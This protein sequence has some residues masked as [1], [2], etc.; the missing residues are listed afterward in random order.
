MDETGHTTLCKSCYSKKNKSWRLAN[1]EKRRQTTKKWRDKNKEKTS[2]YSRQRIEYIK[3]NKPKQYLLRKARTSAKRRNILCD[4]LLSDI[5]DIPEICPVLGIPLFY[6]KNKRTDNTP[7]IDR[8]DNNLGYTKDN[9]II[10]SWRANNLK[11][12]GT[13]DEFRKLT[14]FLNKCQYNKK[15]IKEQKISLINDTISIDNIY[16]LCDWL[17][18]FPRLTKGELTKEFEQKFAEYIG[19][20]FS[21]FVNSG[22]S[23]ILLALLTLKQSNLLNNNKIIIPSLSWATDVSIPDI[24]GFECILCDINLNDLSLELENLENLFIKHNPS[25]LL[26]VSVLGLPP[27]MNEIKYLCDKY[28]V[29]LIE[30]ACESLGSS[31]N[32]KKIGSFGEISVFSSYYGHHFS[33][34]EGGFICTNN[35]KLYELGLM[36]RSHGW[37]R[38]LSINR[39]DELRKK[40]NINEFENLYTFYQPGLNIRNTE[41]GSFLGIQQMDKLCDIVLKREKNFFKMKELIKNNQISFQFSPTDI[42][43]NFAFPCL[44]EER[45]KYITALKNENIEARPLIAGSISLHPW[46]KEKYGYVKMPNAE[47]LHYDGFYLPNH[48]DLT[49]DDIRLI[50]KVINETI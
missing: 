11:H 49:D 39:Q 14:Q 31:F 32:N 16:S 47:R 40:Y 37:S 3:Q 20:K 44:F 28:N 30:D 46:W 45:D 8:I 15:N 34:I 22:S 21:I 19:T 13:Y 2:I 7:S 12:N 43:S 10:I 18:E 42:I 50:S 41:I 29:I 9:I 35:E 4:L 33:T 48:P 25:T 36:I 1:K 38:D 26:L 24:L 27:K 23:A 17:Y 5:P 6:T